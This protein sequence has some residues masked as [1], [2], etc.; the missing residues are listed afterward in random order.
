MGIKELHD[1]QKD[2]TTQKRCRDNHPHLNTSVSPLLFSG[3]KIH[4]SSFILRLHRKRVGLTLVP[5]RQLKKKKQQTFCRSQ[6]SSSSILPVPLLPYHSALGQLL[7]EWCF[8]T[9]NFNSNQVSGKVSHVKK[10]KTKTNKPKKHLHGRLL[11]AVI[12]LLPLLKLPNLLLLQFPQ[13]KQTNST[14][15]G[16]VLPTQTWC[17][18]EDC[19]DNVLFQTKINFSIRTQRNSSV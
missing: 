10:Q 13:A 19:L 8:L 9:Y 15:S 11:H 6:S 12:S 18:I 1:H 16:A 5:R 17:K 3:E 14:H 2:Y 4:C 7:N